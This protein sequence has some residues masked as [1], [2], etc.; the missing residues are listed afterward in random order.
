MT[1]TPSA[2]DDPVSFPRIPP[3][4]P[5]GINLNSATGEITG[6]PTEESPLQVYT[7][8]LVMENLV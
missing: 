8:T 6:T 4:L 5:A 2:T 1:A 7:M 3:T